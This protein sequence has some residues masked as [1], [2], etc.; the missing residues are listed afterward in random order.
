LALISSGLLEVFTTTSESTDNGQLVPLVQE[1]QEN[2][3]KLVEK[4]DAESGFYS[5]AGIAE[6]EKGGIDTALPDSK[7]GEFLASPAEP[8]R[9]I[10][11]KESV[12]F[13]CS[14]RRRLTV[15]EK[16]KESKVYR[17]EEDCRNF[18]RYK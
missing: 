18:P 2:T 13:I 15:W 12:S 5:T 8:V 9:F 3:G 6:L 16:N 14:E 4:V 11:Q 17:A 7:K 1:A 10:Y